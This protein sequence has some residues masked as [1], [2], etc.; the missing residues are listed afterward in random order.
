MRRIIDL[1]F[2]APTLICLSPIFLVVAILVKLQSPGPIL[3]KAKR[4]GQYGH[5]FEMYKFRTMVANADLFGQKL[6]AY[7]DPRITPI[8]FFLRRWKLDEIPQLVNIIKGEMSI[9]GPR[10]ESPA[11]VQ[12]Y[13]RNQQR[14]L[15][16]RPGITGPS[17]FMNRNE[18]EKLR[19][20]SDP[21][22]FYIHILMPEKLKID[23][24]Y[25]KTQTFYSDML[26][27]ART[28]LGI[29]ISAVNS[30]SLSLIIR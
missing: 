1:V 9:I 10:P 23:L 13:T 14:V 16:V 8:G 17:Q 4:V 29:F 3:Y 30:P 2:A 26:W 12:Y 22:Q 15:H 6:T 24:E 19:G 27:I 28:I 7:C 5:I 25:I 21:E 20:K 18:E 11:Y